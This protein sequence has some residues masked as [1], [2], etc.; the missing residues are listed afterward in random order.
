[1]AVPVPRARVALALAATLAGASRAEA[2]KL[3]K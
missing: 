2:G 1:M 3:T